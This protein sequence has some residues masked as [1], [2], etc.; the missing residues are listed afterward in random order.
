MLYCLNMQQAILEDIKEKILPILH[1]AEIKKAALFGSYVKGDSTERSDIDILVAFPEDTTLLDVV[2]LQNKLAEHLQK[3]VDLV[4]YNAIS[5]L[6][7]D[8]ILKYQYPLL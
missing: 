7:K 3:K 5:P 1:A 4:S 8:S 6:L 2:H